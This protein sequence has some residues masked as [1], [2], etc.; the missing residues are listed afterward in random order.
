MISPSSYSAS[1]TPATSLKVTFFCWPEK[2]LARLLPKAMALL[3]PACIWRMKK[4]QKRMR[5]RNGNQLM[6]M[7]R[8]GLRD[9]SLTMILTLLSRRILIRSV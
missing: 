7:V 4:I 6:R 8:N 2:S 3:P 5:R 9:V 1:S